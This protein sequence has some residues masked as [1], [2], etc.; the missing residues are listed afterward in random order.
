MKKI[1]FGL[2]VGTALLSTSCINDNEDAVAVAPIDGA[3][4]NLSVGGATQPNQIWFDLSENQFIKTK[5]TDWDFAF[6]SGSSF[7]VIL[8]SSIQMAA[9]KIPDAT[10]IDAVTTANV[11]ALQP[12]VQVASFSAANEAYIDDVAGNF[13]TGYTAIGE[14][15]SLDSDNGIYLV[16]MGKDVYHGAV[17]VGAVTYNGDPRGWMKIQVV[18]SGEGYKIKYAKLDDTTHKEFTVAKNQLYNYS[19]VTLNHLT[20]QP[21]AQVSIQPEK[22]KWDLCFSVGLN[23]IPGTGSYIYADFIQHNNV[24]NVG[25]YEVKVTA[26][27]TGVNAYNKFEAANIDQSK[28]IYNDHRVLGANWRSTAGVNGPE[29]L[30][31]RFYVVKDA[32]GYYFKLRFTRLTKATTDSQGTAGERGYPS[33]EFKPL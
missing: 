5:R 14:V 31:D 22:K 12:L 32:D 25:V 18:R 33:F 10:N 26:P 2:L 7:K 17:A 23:I 20:A 19:F 4:V 11:A 28:F 30:G 13:P 29:V 8:N 1:L 27:E 9:T 16:N 24:G 15:K 3:L 6:Y 21:A